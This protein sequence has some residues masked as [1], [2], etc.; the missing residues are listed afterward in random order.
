MPTSDR[1][2]AVRKL[3]GLHDRSGR[4]QS[5]GEAMQREPL[6]VSLPTRPKPAGLLPPRWLARDRSERQRIEYGIAPP[7]WGPSRFE[8]RH[9]GRPSGPSSAQPPARLGSTLR[10]R[11]GTGL[12][13]AP[14]RVGIGRRAEVEK[15]RFGLVVPV[16]KRRKRPELVGFAR[17]T[18]NREPRV[19]R[20]Y[21]R[22][23]PVMPV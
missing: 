11:V 19:S 23:A 9:S 17:P 20:R 22:G 1:P 5:R 7:A 16:L 8:S 18:L 21:P 3:R 14:A 10:H 13:F 15:E 12:M 2:S 6:G 4:I